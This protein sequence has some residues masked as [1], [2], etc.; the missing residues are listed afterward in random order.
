MEALAR[1]P[2]PYGTPSDD[3]S[4]ATAPSKDSEVVAIAGP[5]ALN[6]SAPLATPL[7]FANGDGLAF[8]NIT[9]YAYFPNLH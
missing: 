5:E 3:R 9:R 6:V 4:L 2:S 1:S 7:A 8:A